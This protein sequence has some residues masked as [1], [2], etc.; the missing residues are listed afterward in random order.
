MSRAT[1]AEASVGNARASSKLLVC[2]LCVP[3][4]VAAIASNAV[5]AT[6]FMTSCAVSDQPEVWQC[7]RSDNDFGEVVPKRATSS[8][9]SR[10]AA[11][12]LAISMNT[13]MPMAKKNDRRGANASTDMPAAMPVRRYSTPSARV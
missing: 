7:V 12:S 6:L 11:R 9:Q 4:M 10:R 2:R 3:P 13:F 1:F 5:R 8:A